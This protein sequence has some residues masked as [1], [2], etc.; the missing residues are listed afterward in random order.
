MVNPTTYY[1]DEHG[2]KVTDRCVNIG[3]TAY[4]TAAITCVTTA[5]VNP[6]RFGVILAA[7]FGLGFGFFGI[8]SASYKWSVF[9]A[10][11]VML[12]V[13]A[14][15]KMKPVWHLRIATASGEASPLQSPNRQRISTVANA[16]GCAI[17]RR[18]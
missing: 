2:I 17:A 9:G 18:A 8:V 7:A 5:V 14:Y 3:D 10:V 12:C 4:L 11:L 13:A 15:R 16:I 6:R 1:E